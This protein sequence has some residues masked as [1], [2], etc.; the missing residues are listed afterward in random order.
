MEGWVSQLTGFKTG[1]T[2]ITSSG[3]SVNEREREILFGKVIGCDCVCICDCQSNGERERV[4]VCVCV[5]LLERRYE[6]IGRKNLLI[7]PVRRHQ[8]KNWA[9]FNSFSTEVK[10]SLQ[11]SRKKQKM[12]AAQFFKYLAKYL[13]QL[14]LHSFFGGINRLQVS[15][16][17]S[18]FYILQ[19]QILHLD[20]KSKMVVL[21]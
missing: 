16:F 2:P 7:P 14:A 8:V 11:I 4:C 18:N 17:D 19:V 9:K 10:T 3:G 20:E 6:K 13:K 21:K 15:N 5:C 1:F 12:K